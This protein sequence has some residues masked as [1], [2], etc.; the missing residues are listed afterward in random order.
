MTRHAILNKDQH[1]DLRVNMSHGAEYG[2]DIMSALTFP[3]E[4]HN[5]QTYYPIVFQKDEQ[6]NFQPVALFGLRQGEN[7]FLEGSHWDAHYIPLS[8]QREPFLIGRSANGDHVHIDLD[9][10]RVGDESGQALFHDHGGPTELLQHI[11]DVL[12]MLNAGVKNT[13]AYIEALLKHD[14]L[15]SFVL[16]VKFDEDN[17]NRLVGYYTINHDRLRKLDGKALEELSRA[18]H[19]EPTFLAAASL[20]H[21]RDLIERYRNRYARG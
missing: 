10:P 4:F 7:L 18:D 17:E 12:G 21:M 19:L 14:L 3:E 9:H 13:Q 8:V 5:V 6:D 15:E 1:R 16:D 20:T 2:D 11:S